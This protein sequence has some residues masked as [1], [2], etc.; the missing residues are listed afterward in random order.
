MVLL[1]PAGSAQAFGNV[2]TDLLGLDLDALQ[3]W[4]DAS[5]PQ[6]ADYQ[7]SELI[8]TGL[9]SMLAPGGSRVQ[10]SAGGTALRSAPPGIELTTVTAVGNLG[11]RRPEGLIQ[12]GQR[13]NVGDGQRGD[14]YFFAVSD[15]ETMQ[16]GVMMTSLMNEP[17][18]NCDVA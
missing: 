8:P 2:H 16:P 5:T 6:R 11:G 9:P 10:F 13:S 18:V 12:A 3:Q 7:S 14:A 17:A 1:T 4:W 15:L